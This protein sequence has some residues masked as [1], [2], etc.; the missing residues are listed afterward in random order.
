MQE[1]WRGE[2]KDAA[3]TVSVKHTGKKKKKKMLAA[4]KET[5]TAKCRNKYSNFLHTHTCTKLR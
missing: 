5:N 4:A 1:M 3:R 2:R